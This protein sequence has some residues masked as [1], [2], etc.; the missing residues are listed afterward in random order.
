MQGASSFG[1]RSRRLLGALALL[2]GLLAA[3]TCAGAVGSGSVAV[4]ADVPQTMN[5]TPTVSWDVAHDVS[6]PLRDLAAGR[7]PP[8]ADDP[9]GE[10]DR[11]PISD[12][13]GRYSADGALQS[14]QPDAC[15]APCSCSISFGTISRIS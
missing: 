4:A 9:A 10:P 13:D 12:G 7:I 11:G 1:P 2:V 3:A 8:D 15:L 5:P 14:M 6:P